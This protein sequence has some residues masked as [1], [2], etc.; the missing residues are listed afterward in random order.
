MD[1]IVQVKSLL[2]ELEEL[3][4][5]REKSGLESDHVQRLQ[6]KQMT[7]FQANVRALEVLFIYTCVVLCETVLV[8]VRLKTNL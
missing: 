1:F 7:E 8:E 2:S 3:R 6:N 4:S 5:R